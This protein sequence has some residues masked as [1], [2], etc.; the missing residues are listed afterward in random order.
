MGDLQ[1]A[2]LAGV[3][4]VP[5]PHRKSSLA[6][7]DSAPPRHAADCNDGPGGAG[8]QTAGLPAGQTGRRS[9]GVRDEKGNIINPGEKFVERQMLVWRGLN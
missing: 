8:R 3:S 7:P 5:Q 1:T 2:N 4:S 9:G 6:R